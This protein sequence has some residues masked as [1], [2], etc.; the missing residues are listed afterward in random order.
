MVADAPRQFDLCTVDDERE[1]R[2]AVAEVVALVDFFQELCAE[3]WWSQR[4]CESSGPEQ[5]VICPHGRGFA[6][7]SKELCVIDLIV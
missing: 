2:D 1:Q 4:G 3:V 7:A 6:S 5:G